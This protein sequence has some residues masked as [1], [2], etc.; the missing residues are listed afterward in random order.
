[1]TQH[2]QTAELVQGMLGEVGVTV[3]IEAVPGDGFFR[4]FIAPGNFD[5]SDFAWTGTPFPIS[6][7]KPIYA[8]P[9]PG[10]DGRL[11]VQRNYARVGSDE[12]DRLFDQATAELDPAKAVRLANEIDAKIWQEVHS[13]TLFQ[14]PDIV[15]VHTNL[16]NFGAFG[17]ASRAYEDIGFTLP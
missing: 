7:S 2:K 9:K 14:R 4:N 8:N 11:D 12:I 5:L 1:V 16:A 3:E 15:A 13:L 10:S 17:F 6:S